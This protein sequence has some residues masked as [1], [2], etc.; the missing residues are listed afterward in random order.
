[1][2]MATQNPI[3]QEGTYPLPEAQLDRFLMHVTIGYPEPAAE[4]KILHLVRQQTRTSGAPAPTPVTADQVSEARI[5]VSDVFMADAVEDYVLALVLATRD[6][7]ALDDD[8]GRWLSFGVSPR[9]TI[10]LDRCSRALAWLDGRDYVTPDD[11][12]AVAPDV[13]RHRLILTFEAE[14]A[15]ITPD[16]AV[17]RLL[18]RVPVSA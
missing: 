10:A 6:P 3:E 12:R 14:A 1:M 16:Q 7:Q 15:G 2:V 17:Q 8:L 18:E 11:V 4:R 5:A 13:M 9:A